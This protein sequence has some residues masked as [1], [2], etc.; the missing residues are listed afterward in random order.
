MNVSFLGGAGFTVK[1]YIPAFPIWPRCGA[2]LFGAGMASILRFLIRITCMKGAGVCAGQRRFTERRELMFVNPAGIF[3]SGGVEKQRENQG[4]GVFSGKSGEGALRS[5][6]RQEFT[7]W[8]LGRNRE[9]KR[10]CWNMFSLFYSSSTGD[11]RGPSGK[12]LWTPVSIM[13]SLTQ[14]ILGFI[15]NFDDSDPGFSGAHLREFR[16]AVNPVI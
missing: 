5:L 7:G 10:A 4:S 3:R 12:L 8:L 9:G 16:S 11:R 2:L 15:R 6:A 14:N 1:G 13:F